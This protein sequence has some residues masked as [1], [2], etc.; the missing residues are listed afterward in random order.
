MTMFRDFINALTLFVMFVALT[1]ALAS[2][3]WLSVWS[4]LVLACFLQS[5]YLSITRKDFKRQE[6]SEDG[7]CRETDW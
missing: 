7:L 1:Q 6:E 2:G 4:V 3:K 5:S